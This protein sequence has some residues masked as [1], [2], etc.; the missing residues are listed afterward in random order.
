MIDGMFRVSLVET[1]QGR[2]DKVVVWS[3]R[4]QSL[5]RNCQENVQLGDRTW[6]R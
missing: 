6:S 3:A 4:C 1:R 2:F 5:A